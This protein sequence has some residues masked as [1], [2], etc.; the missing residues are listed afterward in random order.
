MPCDKVTY[1]LLLQVHNIQ[2]NIM[3]TL[4]FTELIG[5]VIGLFG[6]RL[7][8]NR[9]ANKLSV[10]FLAIYRLGTLYRYIALIQ[11]VDLAPSTRPH[12]ACL[13]D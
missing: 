1:N 3:T 12:A 7:L 13:R 6:A 9:S 2:M 11:D 5:F 4:A 10:A 8:K